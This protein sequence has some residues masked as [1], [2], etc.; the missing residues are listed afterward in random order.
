MKMLSRELFHLN[1]I[2]MIPTEM[3]LTICLHHVTE[4]LFSMS[5]DWETVKNVVLRNSLS[6]PDQTGTD[7]KAEMVSNT[8]KSFIML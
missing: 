8:Q 1:G 4:Q 5:H 3:V 7:R 2:K 6:K